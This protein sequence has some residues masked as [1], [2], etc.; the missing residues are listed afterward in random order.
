MT[1]FAPSLRLTC[2]NL[3]Q[4]L[5]RRIS[6][7]AFYVGQKIDLVAVSEKGVW[8]TLYSRTPLHGE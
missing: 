5:S 8:A 4:E 2:G 1:A 6:V 3:L 7:M